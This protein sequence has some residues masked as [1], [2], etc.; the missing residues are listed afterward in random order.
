MTGRE[1]APPWSQRK[2]TAAF[3][4]LFL[5]VFL[6]LGAGFFLASRVWAWALS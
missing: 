1:Q 6:T 2:F 3:A 5:A 4:G